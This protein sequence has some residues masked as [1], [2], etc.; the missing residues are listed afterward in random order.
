MRHGCAQ[1]H[2]IR[3]T[4][5]RGTGGPDLTHVG[6]RRTIAAGTLDNHVGTLAGWIADPQTIKP[7][8][9]MPATTTLAG[10]DLRALAAY[11]ASLE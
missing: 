4:A 1:C 10:A 9:R 2:T 8:N 5:A 3:G 6:S 11:L 7:G